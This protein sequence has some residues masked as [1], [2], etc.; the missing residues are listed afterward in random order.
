[1]AYQKVMNIKVFPN[2]KGAAKWGNSKFTPYKDGS[3]ADIYLRSD[4]KYRVSVF[5]ENDGSLGISITIPDEA[6]GGT[7]RVADDV[8][9]G[10]LKKLADSVSGRG[11]NL[12]DDIPF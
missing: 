12:D 1:M 9:Q 8:K 3:P 4:V 7:D 2:D 11:M 6:R 5:E 10:G